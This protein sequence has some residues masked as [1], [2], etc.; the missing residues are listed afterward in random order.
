MQKQ[1]L[2]D[3]FPKQ[4]RLLEAVFDKTTKYILFGG[5]IR[6]GKTYGALGA[7]ILLSKVYPGS[8]WAIVRDSLP[9]LKRNTIPSWNK[10]KPTNFIKSY[11]Q[12]TQVVTFNNGS[13]IIF[14]AENYDDDKELNRWKGLEVN[15]FVLEEG[16]ELNEAS[17]YKAIERAGSH[18]PVTGKKP[19]PLVIITCNPN[20]GYLKKLF[21]DRWKEGTLP[22]GWLYIPAL[23]IDN[24]AIYNDKDYMESLKNLPPNL[25]RIYVEGDWEVND[26]E[27]PWVYSFDRNRHVRPAQFMP[28]YPVYLSF[29]FNNNPFAC[30]AMQK[31]DIL[32]TQSSF[33]SFINEF[34]GHFKLE[35][36][37]VRI[38]TE[39]PKSIL[40]VTGDRNGANEDVGRNQ[41]LYQMIASILNL[42]P[43]QMNL[44]TH[45]LEHADSR[46][47]VN[48]MLHQHPN[49]YISPNCKTLI[50]DMEKATVDIK[51]KTGSVLYKDRDKGHKMDTLDAW[52][53]ANQTWFHEFATK[54]Y[55]RA[56]NQRI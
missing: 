54:E 3:P 21:Y 38:K 6:G 53:Y 18:I 23:V 48:A 26:N 56:L 55:F 14:F 8:R 42:S 27:H 34:V 33:I 44:N 47:L 1:I 36:M 11:N 16:N 35:E 7:A 20:H 32:G 22:E 13:E 51:A 46:I 43:A 17:F 49:Y 28:D 25:Y 24:P 37:L 31:T 29:D 50:E 5:G 41:T 40:Y 2:F 39:Y 12:E 52:R 10:I 19:K 15:G 30:V 9:T 4:I 45:N